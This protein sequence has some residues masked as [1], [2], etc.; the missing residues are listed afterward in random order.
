MV[1]FSVIFSAVLSRAKNTNA[2]S[3]NVSEAVRRPPI[4]RCIKNT[5]QQ[6]M[7]QRIAAITGRPL[8]SMYKTKMFERSEGF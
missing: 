7:Q 8:A 3:L 2:K 4:G 6:S 1:L 5:R